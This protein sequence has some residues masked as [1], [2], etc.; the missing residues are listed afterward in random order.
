MLSK[1]AYAE[2]I[3]KVSSKKALKSMVTALKPETRHTV[4][5][6]AEV[7]VYILNTNRLRVVINARDTTSLRAA[8]NSYLRWIKAMTDVLKALS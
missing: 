3:I 1:K 7:R 5:Q 4:S 6:R 2:I 8:I